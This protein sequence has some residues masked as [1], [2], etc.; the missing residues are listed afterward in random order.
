ME[1]F[2]ERQ[3]LIQQVSSIKHIFTLLIC[4]TYHVFNVAEFVNCSQWLHFEPPPD[5]SIN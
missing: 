1:R 2:N 5:S 3:I 4:N